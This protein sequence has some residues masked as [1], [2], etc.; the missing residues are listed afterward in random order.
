MQGAADQTVACV[1]TDSRLLQ[2]GDLFFALRGE[3]F[4]GHAFLAEAARK[5]AAAVVAERT[6]MPE[7]MSGCGVVAVMR[8]SEGA[9]RRAVNIP[10][11]RADKQYRVS[12]VFSGKEY[13]LFSG[14]RLQEPGLMVE[15]PAYGQDLLEIA[16]G[17]GPR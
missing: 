16:V 3:R 14:R 1:C 13:G 6:A 12:G 10:W 4:D 5:G 15:L 9:P 11:V 17:V 8:G 7:K 2:P